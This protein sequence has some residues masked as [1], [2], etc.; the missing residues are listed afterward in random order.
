MLLQ[1]Y[2]CLHAYYPLFLSDFNENRMSLTISKNKQIPN[3]MKIRPVRDE[4][5]HADGGGGHTD[6]TKLIESFFE[7]FRK[8]PKNTEVQ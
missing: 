4:L 8:S 5:F 3:F 7:I 1:M 6:M 2:L